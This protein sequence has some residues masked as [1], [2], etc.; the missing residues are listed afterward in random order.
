MGVSVG[1]NQWVGFRVGAEVD[2]ALF[3]EVG[4][5][6]GFL[7]VIGRRVGLWVGWLGWAVGEP[8]GVVLMIGLEVMIP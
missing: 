7:V 6:V 8:V 3:H 2:Q 1:L 4:T 5:L